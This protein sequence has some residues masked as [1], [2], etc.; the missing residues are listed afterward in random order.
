MRGFIAVFLAALIVTAS[1]SPAVS[2]KGQNSGMIITREAPLTIRIVLVGFDPD[3]IDLD[4]LSWKGNTIQEIANNVIST[5]N[6]TGV[7]YKFNYEFV[8]A[9]PEFNRTFTKFLKS[10][11]V[12]KASYNPWFRSLAQNYFYDSLEVE[13]WLLEN[14]AGYGGFPANGY[15]FVYMNMTGLPSI[16]EAQLETQNAMATTPHYY[17][18]NYT[19]IDLDYKI[20]YREFAVAWGGRSRLWFMDLS[21]GPEF[22]TWSQG[23]GIPHIPIQLAIDLYRINIHTA[24]GQQWLTQYLS[25]Y[26]YE[27]V[28]NLATP[29]FVY[30]PTFSRHY[31]IIVNVIDNRTEDEKQA[32]PIDTTIRPDIIQNAFAELLPYANVTIETRFISP[33]EDLA[34]QK[35]METSTVHPPEDTGI[36]PFVDTRP[37]YR[38]LEEHLSQ[39]AGP[40]RSDINEVTL[41]VF[42][43]AFPAGM[44]FGYTNKW[45]VASMKTYD[46]NFLGISLGDLS[47]IGITQNE[48]LR[49]DTVGQPGKGLGLTQ[50][51]IHE[52]GHSLGLPHPH[53]FGYLEDFES[54]PMSY[55]SYEYNFSQFDK[56]AINRAHADELINSAIGNLTIARNLLT[57]RLDF[58]LA[59]L[60]ADYANSV[61]EIALQ[62]YGRMNYVEAV[63]SAEAAAQLSAEAANS[64]ASSPSAVTA[65]GLVSL[66]I[67]LVIGS[68]LMFVAFRKYEK[69]RT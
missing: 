1:L 64:L 32:V 31:D 66:I 50:T 11:E 20:R 49:G 46:T 18:R 12:R 3:T 45:Y 69:G 55:W 48:F 27:A 17:S 44:Y 59:G 34:L 22:W 23:G 2:A 58:N 9:P 57:G 5:G 65:T 15:T 4:Y 7:N 8:F 24:Y 16:T 21:A 37:I 52:V 13:S 56:D 61:L 6:V 26:I 33:A 62:Q 43:F 40:L 14:N 68:S 53:Q 51:I 41:P 35:I 28:L 29:T 25:D 54:S 63:Q 60:K 47:L 67:G 36:S 38:F 39:F 10:I 19:D 42:A 30:Q